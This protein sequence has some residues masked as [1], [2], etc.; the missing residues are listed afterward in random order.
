MANRLRD[1]TYLHLVRQNEQ[2]A[3][4]LP[5]EKEITGKETRNA[6]C[7][8]SPRGSQT[9]RDAITGLPHT[10]WNLSA[11]PPRFADNAIHFLCCSL[12]SETHFFRI[13]RGGAHIACQ[14]TGAATHLQELAFPS[15]AARHILKLICVFLEETHTMQRIFLFPAGKHTSQTA[16]DVRSEH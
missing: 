6:S 7:L 9:L 3:T 10:Q 16:F 4:C 1:A 8:Q 14:D 11:A 12:R 13:A 2:Y 5:V 15:F